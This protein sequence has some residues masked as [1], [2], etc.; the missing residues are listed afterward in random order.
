MTPKK[1]KQGD[2]EIKG[3]TERERRLDRASC[4][5]TREIKGETEWRDSFMP[6][7]LIL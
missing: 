3:D 5:K 6:Y 7:Y 2:R 1:V 4:M